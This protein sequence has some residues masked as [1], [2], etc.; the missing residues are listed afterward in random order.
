MS[1][2]AMAFRAEIQERIEDIKTLLPEP[3][4]RD[5]LIAALAAILADLIA[6]APE[7][8]RASIAA[9]VALEIATGADHLARQET[10]GGTPA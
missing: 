2:Q 10:T 5:A 7:R 6:E 3:F 1:R 4:R 9:F 8:E